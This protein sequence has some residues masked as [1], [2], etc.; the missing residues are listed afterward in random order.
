MMATLL[1][2]A[3]GAAQTAAAAGP[4]ATTADPMAQLVSGIL[5]IVLIMVVFY[6]L[7]IGPQKKEQK[8]HAEMLKA[9]KEGDK[10]VTSGGI[11]GIVS[12]FSEKDD[13]VSITVAGSTK[14]NV[15]RSYVANKIERPAE[16]TLSEPAKK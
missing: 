14:L 6:F 8:K 10:V 3:N 12:G 13:I 7:I 15:M 4:G 5:P 11:V 9:I 1:Y 2:A 16:N